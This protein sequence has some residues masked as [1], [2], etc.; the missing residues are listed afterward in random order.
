MLV[1]QRVM[2]KYVKCG[3]KQ[4]NGLEWGIHLVF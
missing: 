4:H 2:L 3:L 1:Y